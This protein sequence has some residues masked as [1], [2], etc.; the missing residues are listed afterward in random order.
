MKAYA[1][2]TQWLRTFVLTT[3]LALSGNVWATTH[4]VQFGG[5]A[6]FAYAPASFSASIGDTVKWE[7]DFSMHPLSS[8]TIP[9]NSQSWHVTSGTIFSYR[10]AVPGTYNYQ[11]DVHFSI[12]MIGSFTA[13]SSGVLN[14]ASPIYPGPGSFMTIVA[15]GTSVEPFVNFVVSRTGPV[16]LKILDLQ[17]REI[18]VVINRILQEGKY[19]VS[20]GVGVKANGLYCIKLLANNQSSSETIYIP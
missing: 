18:A 15:T 7:G 16:T 4:V 20:L 1:V 17:G 3:G 5:S 2:F 14:Q 11:C 9:A 6:G 12:G 10:I 8:T 19:T 13:N